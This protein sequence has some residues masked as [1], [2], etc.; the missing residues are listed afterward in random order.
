MVDNTEVA[1][2]DEKYR[3]S[4]KISLLDPLEFMPKFFNMNF[5]T[6]RKSELSFE[7]LG[8]Y[9]KISALK[10]EIEML[11]YKIKYFNKILEELENKLKLEGEN[12]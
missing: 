5:D 10:S 1:D 3:F 4:N 12:E 6:G 2:M 11:E 9:R 7:D 8:L